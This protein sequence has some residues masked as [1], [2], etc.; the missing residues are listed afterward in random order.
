MTSGSTKHE[1]LGNYL[2][3]A[4]VALLLTVLGVIGIAPNQA[5]G[6]L[7]AVAGGSSGGGGIPSATC[8]TSGGLLYAS[9]GAITCNINATT[10]GAGNISDSAS[11]TS[12]IV[13]SAGN[14]SIRSGGA[15]TDAATVANNLFTFNGATTVGSG[16]TT[17]AGLVI[18]YLGISGY[19]ALYP[20]G[21]TRNTTNFA[22]ATNGTDTIL[23]APS[24]SV[25]IGV[26]NANQLTYNGTSLVGANNIV[27]LGVSGGAFSGLAGTNTNNSAAAGF[28][29][30]FI[31]SSVAS[32][33]AIVMNSGTPITTV[34]TGATVTAGDYDAQGTACYSTAIATSIT[35]LEQGISTSNNTFS[36]LGSYTSDQ[37][38]AMVPLATGTN[39]I[40]RS[41]PIVRI[42]LSGTSTVFLVT[43]GV[44]TV[45]TLSSYGFLRLR[46]VR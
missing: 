15:S 21:V 5:N 18:D 13:Q 25:K 4:F 44:F 28:V 37:F 38:A 6:A 23:N 19:G 11:V 12:P 1:T 40:C 7:R 26:A 16:T 22:L 43:R 29:G 14:L 33:G 24:G 46:R 20:T 3:V 36:T 9:A 2:S 41:T 30:E 17:S 10:D 32:S 27:S 34:S 31:S 45:S 42:S 8:S 35:V 39:E